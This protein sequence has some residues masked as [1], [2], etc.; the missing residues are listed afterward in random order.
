MNRRSF[1]RAAPVAGAVI[2]APALVLSATPS[3]TMTL[4]ELCDYHAGLLRDTLQKLHGGMWDCAV[5][6][7]TKAALVICKHA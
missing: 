3:Q 2:A 4:E 6:H 5:N 7:R 1:L